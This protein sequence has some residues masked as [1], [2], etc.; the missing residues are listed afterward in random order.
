MKECWVEQNKVYLLKKYYESDFENFL[1][2]TEFISEHLLNRFILQISGVLESLHSNGVVHLDIKPEN[3]LI[4]ENDF[5]L[6]DFGHA[7]NLN[8][9]RD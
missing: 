5:Y 4:D 2:K 9:K 7:K 6:N 1:Q 8:L 3:I